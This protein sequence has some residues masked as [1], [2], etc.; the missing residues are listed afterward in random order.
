M[1][2]VTQDNVDQVTSTKASALA[3]RV[4]SGEILWY[5]DSVLQRINLNDNLNAGTDWD[6]IATTYLPVY[7]TALGEL[8]AIVE[9]LPRWSQV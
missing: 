1:P 9:A 5:L 2:V 7:D 4:K 3:A 6:E 8:K